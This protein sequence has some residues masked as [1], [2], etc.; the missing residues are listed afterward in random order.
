MLGVAGSTTDDQEFTV[1]FGPEGR[2]LAAGSSKGVVQRWNVSDPAHP[3]AIGEP[4]PRFPTGVFGVVFTPDGSTMLA[5]GEGGTIARWSLA[6]PQHPVELPGLP[7]V[8][9]VQTMAISPDGSLLAVGGRAADLQLW[10]LTGSDGP[11][12]VAAI[13]GA[14]SV[15]TA[16]AFSPDGR[17]LAVGGRDGAV[18]VWNVSSPAAPAPID[19]GLTPFTNIA[20]VVTFSADGS[21]LAAAGSDGTVRSWR[22]AGW[23]PIGQLGHPAPVTGLAAT[24]DGARLFSSAADGSTRT[25]TTGG[26]SIGPFPDSVFS[27]AWMADGRRLAAAPGPAANAMSI[28]DV[29]DP[30][31]AVEL[32]TAAPPDPDQRYGGGVAVSPDGRLMAVTLTDGRV[33]LWSLADPSR[34]E[35]LG[36]PLSGPADIVQQVTFSADGRL[37]AGAAN[38]ASVWLWN[39]TDPAAPTVQA[40]MTDL[41]GPVYSVA[42]GDGDRML[43]ASTTAGQA[44][45]W[46]LDDPS[47]PQL[48]STIDAGASYSFA[49]VV[50]PD[51]RYLAVAGADREVRRWDISDP[52]APSEVGIPLT[53]PANDVYWVDYS[54]D[55]HLLAAASTDGYVWLWDNADPAAPQP[56]A[57]LGAARGPLFVAEFGRQGSMIAAGGSDRSIHRWVTDPATAEAMICAA[58]GAPMTDQEWQTFLPGEPYDPP[59]A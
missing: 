18:T 12:Q 34:P 55:G 19:A 1:S 39:V 15:V 57:T 13:P 59:C 7:T 24:A 20:N 51:G 41:G 8:G 31:H 21:V 29:G 40:A 54:P 30:E 17:T 47:T 35:A 36:P 9:L 26:A 45:V 28:W 3:V 33:Q 2:T 38:D 58:I 25:W 27:L 44:K 11:A 56:Y 50:S 37:L 14:Q 23:E 5:G 52:A 22:T 49:V 46:T 53:G 16:S 4:L 48:R 32:A 43:A 6:D 10:S 42:F